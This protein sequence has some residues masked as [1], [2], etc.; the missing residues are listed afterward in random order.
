[1]SAVRVMRQSLCLR[2]FNI[3]CEYNFDRVLFFSCVIAC[4][5]ACG[6]RDGVDVLLCIVIAVDA[7]ILSVFMC[8]IIV[9]RGSFANRREAVSPFGSPSR[10]LL[11]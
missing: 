8:H 2:F 10:F 6:N 9:R 4:I 3:F 5:V 1:M 11:N 7:C